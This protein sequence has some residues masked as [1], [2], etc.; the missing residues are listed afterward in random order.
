MSPSS[1]RLDGLTSLR[2]FAAMAIVLFHCDGVFGLGKG[3]FALLQG[4]SFFYV[5]SGFILARVYPR[6]AGRAAVFAFWRARVARIWPA[7]LAALA[8]GAW[9]LGYEWRFGTALAYLA[10]VQSWVPLPGYYFSYN[11]VGW[12]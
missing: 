7:Y 1:S 9:L 3:G 12:S 5:L 11:G 8:I 4:V 2:F 6:L 10:M